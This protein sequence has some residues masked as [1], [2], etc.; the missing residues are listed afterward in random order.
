MSPNLLPDFA[1]ELPPFP[2][3]IVTFRDV[4]VTMF[5]DVLEK[6]LSPNVLTIG[7]QP[8][9]H[10]T[11]SFKTKSPGAKMCLRTSEMAFDF[12]KGYSG[13]ALTAYEKALIDCL[14]GDT[15]LFWHR[16]GIDLAWSFIDPVLARCEACGE[17]DRLVPIYEAGSEGPAEAL[18]LKEGLGI[19]D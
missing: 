13:P 6:G 18:R 16:E 14:K 7:I 10:I 19:E 9:E 11:L 12:L 17:K 3:L 4:P 2:T 1:H 8:R 15:M 5:G